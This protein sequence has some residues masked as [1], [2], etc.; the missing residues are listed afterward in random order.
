MHAHRSRA[1]AALLGGVWLG[2]FTALVPDVAQAIDGT[3]TGP[4]TEWTTGTNWSS[5]PSVPDGTATFTNNGAPTSVTITNFSP[6]EVTIG[7]MQFTAGAPTYSFT[8]AGTFP[9]TITGAGIVNNSSNAQRFVNAFMNF[10]NSSTAG[11]ANF[12]GSSAILFF[13]NSSAANAVISQT[14]GSLVFS[15][16]STAGNATINVSRLFIGPPSDA[17]VFFSGNSSAGSANIGMAVSTTLRFDGASTA[18]NAHISSSGTLQFAS[19]STAGS[20]TIF[21]GSGTASFTDTSTAGNANITNSGVAG[22]S[23][24]LQFLSSSTAGNAT[25]TNQFLATTFFRGNSTAG[26]ARLINEGTF[27]FSATTGPA[28]NRQITAGSIEGSGAF[29]LGANQLTVGSNNLSTAVSGFIQDG[30]MAGGTGGSLVKVGLGTLTLSGTNSYTGATTVNAGTLAVTGSIANSAVTVNSG[31][32]LTGTGTLGALTINGGGTFAPAGPLGI[33]PPFGSPGAMTVTG[34]LAFQSGALYV[35]QVNPS[36]ASSTNV[37]GSATLAGTVQAAFA[38]GSYA[39]RNYT[40][41]SAAGGLNGTTFNALTTSNLPAGFAANLSYT[42]TN[43]ILN[44]IAGLGQPGGPGLVGSTGLSGNQQNVANAINSFFNNGGA[45]PPAFVSLFG[46]TG[47]NLANALTALSGEAATGSQQ[48]G[49]QLTNQFLSLMLDPFVDG[50]SGMT[51]VGGPAMGFAP[52]REPVPEQ[53][54]LAYASVLKEPKAPKP[55]PIYEPRWSVWGSGFGGANRTSGDPAVVGSHDLSASVAGYAGGFDYRMT[56]DTVVGLAF[57]GA[58]TNW[59]LAQGLGTGKSDAFQTGIYGVTRAG[60]SYL[61]AAFA[62]ANHWMSTDRFAFAGDHLTADFQAQSLGGR[63]EGGYRFASIYGGLTPYAAIQAQ[64]FR[65]PSYSE[66]DVNGGGFA[67]AYNART[68]T[69]TRGELGA[70]FDRLIALHPSAALSLRGRLAWAHDWVSDPTLA[71]AFQTLPGASFLVNGATP[72]KNSALTSAGAEYRL[73]NGISLLA[74][75]D[76]EFAAHS[77]TYAGTGI[78]RYAW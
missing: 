74:K 25:I 10:L 63:I 18:A 56:P 41:V 70:R 58:G 12:T 23:G 24:G 42:N 75:F 44:L 38:P 76:G 13:G 65:T 16:N 67:L 8:K 49:F 59:S 32:T 55:P 7:T 11:N 60:P 64:S 72:A 19:S 33:A 62:Y 29:F 31:A 66:T 48:V 14:N 43:V 57:A 68:G 46:L 54:S 26:N 6:N 34:N 45:L 73:A 78:V 53:I 77:S 15:D 30:G 27:D 39:A 36:A 35:V 3:W 69:D 20:A 50:R 61:A 9:F 47:G 52:E 1:R 51:G 71:A 5:S 22:V 40:I 37:S 21:N 17:L 2:A 4:G 28:G